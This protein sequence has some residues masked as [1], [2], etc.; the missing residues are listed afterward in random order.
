MTER[1]TDVFGFTYMQVENERGTI[2]IACV[3]YC[4][5]IFGGVCLY[6][7]EEPLLEDV[8]DGS[9]EQRHGQEDKQLVSE[10]TPVVLE[11]ELAAQVDGS[12]HVLE[13]LV[14]LQNRPG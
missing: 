10:L 14:G 4:V 7:R 1:Q 9:K 3:V 13:L 6:E 2:F 5:L 11:D 12:C 8:E